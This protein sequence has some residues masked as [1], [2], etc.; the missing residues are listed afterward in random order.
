MNKRLLM[1]LMPL[2]FQSN[3]YCEDP[4]KDID[5]MIMPQLQS[6]QQAMNNSTKLELQRILDALISFA[7]QGNNQANIAVDQMKFI[8]AALAKYR[9]EEYKTTWDNIC[10]FFG[11]NPKKVVEEID[12]AIDKVNTALKTLSKN[13]SNLGYT[14]AAGIAG[15]AALA[16]IAAAALWVIRSGNSD[17]KKDEDEAFTELTL[18]QKIASTISEDQTGLMWQLAYTDALKHIQQMPQTE[19]NQANSDELFTKLLQV[20]KTDMQKAS[21]Y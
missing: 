17:S 11:S 10:W 13:S 6:A 3:I 9:T 2:L 1:V 19:R 8:K 5:Q 12:P 16:T 14:V 21:T 7:K 15:G 20:V 18:A 4:Y